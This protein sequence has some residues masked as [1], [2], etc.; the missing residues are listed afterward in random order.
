VESWSTNDLPREHRAERAQAL[1]GETHLPWDL[2]GGGLDPAHESW[3]RHTRISDVS[4]VDSVASP[5]T[6][7]RGPAQL[8]ATE[9][10]WLIVVLGRHGDTVIE[11]GDRTSVVGGDGG[12]VL[13]STRPVELRFPERVAK[14]YMLVP[15]WRV[16]GPQSRDHAVLRAGSPSLGMLRA[17]TDQLAGTDPLADPADRATAAHV[18]VELLRACMRPSAVLEPAA[19]EAGLHARA[20]EHIE[21]RLGERGL[22]PPAIAAALGVSVRTLHAAFAARGETVS[23]QIRELRLQRAHADLLAPGAQPVT[24]IPYRWAFGSPSHF[25]RLFKERFG[26]APRELRGHRDHDQ[27][28]D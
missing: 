14:R 20:C 2:L 7:R 21:R 6:V 25:S 28:D 23:G 19:L 22:R 12:A 3:V 1:L 8:R 15:A 17:F 11:Q 5:C 18:V 24:T 10:E 27:G 13:H 16:A 9:G 4:I 26:A